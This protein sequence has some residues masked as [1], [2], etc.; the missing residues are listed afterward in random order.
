MKQVVW[1]G[2]VGGI[3]LGIGTLGCG[4]M[5]SEDDWGERQHAEICG[6]I[7]DGAYPA[8]A[9][10]AV[11]AGWELGRWEATR[12]MVFQNDRV[13]LTQVALNRCASLGFP[14]CDNMTAALALQDAPIYEVNGQRLFDPVQYRQQVKVYLERQ[15]IW[16]SR[17]C[18]QPN[19][20]WCAIHKSSLVDTTFE[21]CGQIYWFD[22]NVLWCWGSECDPSKVV[23]KLKFAGW[24]E[25]GWLN[26]QVDLS[27][28]VPRVGIDPDVINLVKGASPQMEDGC[29]LNTAMIYDD[30]GEYDGV[31]CRVAGEQGVFGQASWNENTRVCQL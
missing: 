9:S 21:G 1:T 18:G 17:L 11:T 30:V 23:T 22:L 31:C 8:L 6:P 7:L 14:R 24:P 26:P 12:D 19:A 5:V 13:R 25:N 3:L 29:V 4:G 28:P 15:Q 2:L 16:E 20:A 10:L 27:G